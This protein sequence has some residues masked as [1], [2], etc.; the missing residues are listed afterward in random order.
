M[1]AIT[2]LGPQS[3]SFVTE[4][5]SL[6]ASRNMV[7]T[8]ALARALTLCSNLPSTPVEDI[9]AFFRTHV[10]PE[11][12]VTLSAVNELMV[13]DVKAVAEYAFKFYKVRYSAAH[14]QCNVFSFACDTAVEDFFNISRSVDAAAI[15]VIRCE[16]STIS[17]RLN[18]FVKLIEDLTKKPESAAGAA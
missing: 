8:L 14:P 5:A 17:V 9:D 15:S 2:K 4:M 7:S 11:L 12:E 13:V 18:K 3:Q 10:Q 6:N 1:F 16:A